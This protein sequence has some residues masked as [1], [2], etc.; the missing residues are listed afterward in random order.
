MDFEALQSYESK[1][2]IKPAVEAALDIG[3]FSSAKTFN[4]SLSK[5]LKVVMRLYLPRS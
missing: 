3:L 5:H 4:P 1:E 2:R